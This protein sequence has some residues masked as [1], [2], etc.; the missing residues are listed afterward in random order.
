MTDKT[1]KT[2]KTPKRQVSF[3]VNTEE[4]AS[5][6]V[7]LPNGQSWAAE[8]CYVGIAEKLPLSLELETLWTEDRQ[9]YEGTQLVLNVPYGFSFGASL[10]S[11]KAQKVLG[12]DAP[13]VF[14][15]KSGISVRFYPYTLNSKGEVSSE[16]YTWIPNPVLKE[17]LNNVDLGSINYGDPKEV[18]V[19]WEDSLDELF[20]ILKITD[21]QKELYN[22]Y[23]EKQVLRG[24]NAVNYYREFFATIAKDLDG[25]KVK[26]VVCQKPLSTNKEKMANYIDFGDRYNQYS[27]T[28]KYVE[29]CENDLD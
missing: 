15:Q 6:V 17:L 29:G 10:L 16:S 12:K 2:D 22:K 13:K 7:I 18:D 19:P 27:G 24:L 5:E 14:A 28:L 20:D 25:K 1:D 11:K 3:A 9:K 21:E 26:V 4:M 23:P 8:L